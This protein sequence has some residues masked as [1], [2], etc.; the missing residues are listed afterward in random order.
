MKENERIFTTPYGQFVIDTV[1]DAKMADVFKRGD[2]HQSDTIELLSK[3][4]TTDSVFVD[5]GAHVGTIT[6][7]MARKTA[8]T[9]AYEAD[10]STY[11]ILKQN[12]ELNGVRVNVRQRG[13]GAK[14]GY[15]S[16]VSTNNGN[17]GAHALTIGDGGVRVVTLD[18]E[19]Q[20][21]D[22]MK[23]D[24]EGMEFAVL[25]GAIRILKRSHPV[26]LFEVNISQL[27]AHD[28]SLSEIEMFLR[29]LGYYLY[30]PFRS[31]GQ[32][33][34]GRVPRL[35]L[36][37]LLYYPG[38][39]ILRRISSV[40]DI[41]AI[42]QEQKIPL[43]TVSVFRTVLYVIAENARNKTYRMRRLFHRGNR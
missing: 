1:A 38:A 29:A 39:Y 33:V 19:L 43:P 15:G 8:F 25:Q 26:V 20:H 30:L 17:A 32:L 5:G 10:T 28:A 41:V 35:P 22:V 36:I 42:S 2:Y 7:P 40:F 11:N 31:H 13:L 27:R 16:I 12:V 18:D 23:L 37:A 21:I 24:V 9:I 6:V 34:L 3:F 4:I 14:T